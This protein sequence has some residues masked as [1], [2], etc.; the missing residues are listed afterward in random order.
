MI[1]GDTYEEVFIFDQFFGEVWSLSC[2]SVG[3]F[4]IAGGSDKSLR[5]FVQTQEQTFV[6]EEVEKREE[7][8]M[9]EEE[10]KQF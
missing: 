5:V 7:K 6:S 8:M 2:S 10:E 3:D 1:D 9:L 4:F